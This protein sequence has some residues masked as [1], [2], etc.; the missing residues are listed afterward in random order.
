MA[1]LALY[2]RNPSP[3]LTQIPI[4]AH[5]QGIQVGALCVPRGEIRSGYVLP[6]RAGQ[7]PKL[8]LRRRLRLA[9]ELELAQVRIAADASL[10][11]NLPRS[12]SS[13]RISITRG[14]F[15]RSS[16]TVAR[17]VD[18]LPTTWRSGVTS[19]WSSQRL[20]RGLKMPARSPVLG[21]SA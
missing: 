21:S 20:R 8:V 1:M 2:R 5:R 11:G 18:V 14:R 7:Q 19:K 12:D 16:S 6:G 15:I 13:R 9:I 3:F 10:Y 17:P 4:R